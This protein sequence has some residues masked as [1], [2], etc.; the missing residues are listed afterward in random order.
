MSVNAVKEQIALV[1]EAGE[2]V[3][4][5]S[6]TTGDLMRVIEPEVE[7]LP[8]VF[9]R[10]FAT[11]SFGQTPQFHATMGAEIRFGV[12][13]T[14]HSS[15]SSSW[16]STPQFGRILRACG[17][18]FGVLNQVLI[19]AITGGPF[20]S[21][22]T[23]TGGTSGTEAVVLGDWYTG[24]TTI[25]VDTTSGSFTAGETITG[26]TSGA[27]AT[28]AGGASAPNLGGTQVGLYWK[29]T[30]ALNS[31]TA[32]IHY[33]NDTEREVIYG[34]RG[35]VD[36]QMNVHNRVVMQC[37]FR[38]IHKAWDSPGSSALLDELAA[39]AYQT[40][41]PPAFINSNTVYTE[42]K[43]SSPAVLS[44]ADLVFPDLTV[45]LGNQLELR[46]S[47][48]GSN[49]YLACVINNRTPN[50]QANLDQPG[51][52]T[53][54]FVENMLSGQLFRLRTGWGTDQYN[55]FAMRMGH[56]EIASLQ[57][58]ENL[59]RSTW[60]GSFRLTRG[61]AYGADGN[62]VGSDNELFLFHT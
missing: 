62:T 35:T 49:G 5:T 18:D 45:S 1:L 23:I 7:F 20:Q 17:M 12:E 53:Y 46:S 61:L 56:V 47:A 36:F 30:S 24:E 27:T 3:E 50:A 48:N 44:G 6:H 2:G 38:G 32:T 21:G 31:R 25:Y 9:E 13:L 28:V 29:M 40:K 15:N 33:L 22:E 10:Q 14:G 37:T 59:S 4:A 16:G 39:G 60:D 42:N 58:G 19:G 26:G 34:A 51:A 43:A 57:P 11:S 52:D 8:N 41:Y 54:N 55:R